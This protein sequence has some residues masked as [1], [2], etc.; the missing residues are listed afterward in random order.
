V[1]VL[2]G[3]AMQ[4]GFALL[5]GRGLDGMRDRM[6]NTGHA[7]FARVATE[8]SSIFELVSDYDQ[9]LA[10]GELG[11]YAQS[12]PPGQLVLYMV[13]ERIGGLIS[14][15]THRAEKI[16][17]LR[18]V[19]AL[20]WP[21][22]SYLVVFPLFSLTRKIA[23]G[24]QAMIASVLYLFVPSVTLITLHTDQV[25]FPL[26]FIIAIWLP[27][28][29]VERSSLG[30]GFLAGAFVYFAGFFTFPMFLALPLAA[31][32]TIAISF[33][34]N[35]VYIDWRRFLL[36]WIA[37]ACGVLAAD[38][39]FRLIFDYNVIERFNDAL[40]F[41]QKWKAWTPSL[42][43]HLEYGLSS[44]L[45]FIVFLGIPLTFLVGFNFRRSLDK[46]LLGEPFKYVLPALMLCALLGYLAFF[47]K[48][49]NESARLWLF[50]VPLCCMFAAIEISTRFKNHKWSMLSLV[51]ALQWA[52]VYLTKINQDFR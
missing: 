5:E 42:T 17:R 19:A 44:L 30:L 11:R 38:L 27:T 34:K 24:E 12:K 40:M 22:I 29:S 20:I 37:I 15:P 32:F 1:V 10:T 50:L 9:K 39:L 6:V 48:T 8:Q 13:T 3:F 43:N 46:V 36:I 41:H 23:D 52:T 2:I 21:L 47:G 49:K 18:F 28:V 16:D 14:T 45:E 25:F 31:A 51:L 33:S 26:F 4:H 7:E 35:N